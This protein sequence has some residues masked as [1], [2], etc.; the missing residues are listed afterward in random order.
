MKKDKTRTHG[1][2]VTMIILLVV[3][4]FAALYLKWYF[5]DREKEIENRQLQEMVDYHRTQDREIT[6]FE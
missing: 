3:G 2:S 5:C 4:F 6:V 1:Y